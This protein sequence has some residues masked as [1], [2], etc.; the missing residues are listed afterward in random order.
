MKIKLIATLALAL[1]LACF[2]AEAP[3]ASAAS[4]IS[5]TTSSAV[6]VNNPFTKER[7][8]AISSLST[9]IVML[10][11]LG[12]GCTNETSKEKI[13]TSISDWKERN[14]PFLTMHSNY[15]SG[16]VASMKEATSEAEAQQFLASISKTSNEQ[17]NAAIKTM[18]DKDGK[19][20]T[21]E[22]YFTFVTAGKLDIKKGYPE[23]KT[24]KEM[25]D[26]ST[27]KA[28]KAKKK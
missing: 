28:P 24:L 20:L 21:C 25:L 4:A 22:K 17:A 15:L 3:T 10:Q 13:T 26:A 9:S 27:G 1:P 14:K 11:K 2:A 23:Y 12:N 8:K 18:I 5:N 19:D 16:L 7:N 6:P